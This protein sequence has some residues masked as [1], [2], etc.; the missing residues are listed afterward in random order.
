MFM[1]FCWRVSQQYK[2]KVDLSLNII[3]NMTTLHLFRE[4]NLK[5]QKCQCKSGNVFVIT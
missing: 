1:E 5:I 2:M 4:K 3:L